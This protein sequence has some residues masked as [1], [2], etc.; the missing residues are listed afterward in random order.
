MHLLELSGF[1]VEAEF[2]DFLG[3]APAYGKEQ[4]WVARRA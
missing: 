4:L 3:G 1:A 2:S